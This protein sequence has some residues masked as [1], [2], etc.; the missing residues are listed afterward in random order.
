MA[1]S[2]S[3]GCSG[4]VPA[5]MDTRTQ[6]SACNTSN[7]ISLWRHTTN[8]HTYHYNKHL[9][10]MCNLN[11]FG[12]ACYAFA[13]ILCHIYNKMDLLPPHI[14]Y[15]IQ[16]L[17]LDIYYKVKCQ[18]HQASSTQTTKNFYGK[19]NYQFV[20]KTI[21]IY[22]AMQIMTFLIKSNNCGNLWP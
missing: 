5:L 11:N 21:C 4:R 22:R 1:D 19:V 7:N 13:Q 12:V 17:E 10:V 6:C 2:N 8:N 20:L 18:A 14:T 9:S 16:L 15:D 3:S